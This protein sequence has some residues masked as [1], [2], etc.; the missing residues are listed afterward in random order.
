LLRLRLGAEGGRFLLAH[1]LF[2][3]IE[4]RQQV[5][6]MLEAFLRLSILLLLSLDLSPSFFDFLFVNCDMFHH[7]FSDPSILLDL[8]LQTL[9]RVP[10]NEPVVFGVSDPIEYG[11]LLLPLYGPLHF[12]TLLPQML[13]VPNG[14]QI[15]EFGIDFE[16]LCR[17]EIV[18]D[19]ASPS[20]VHKVHLHRLQRL[21]VV[22]VEFFEVPL[23]QWVVEGR[24]VRRCHFLRVPA[25]LPRL[26]T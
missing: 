17:Q 14:F 18:R 8:F 26:T 16:L 3:V 13:Q 5:Q 23:P 15:F 22:K 24:S 20:L 19:R 21:H 9:M 1:D 7:F 10:C 6:L 12:D 11:L 4:A 2:H 25:P